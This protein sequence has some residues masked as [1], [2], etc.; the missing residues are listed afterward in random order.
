MLM[1]LANFATI[2]R[3][4]PKNLVILVINNRTYLT[5]DRGELESACAGR[6][7]L[8]G[9]ARAMGID[10]AVV[11][12]TPEQCERYIRQAM[13]EDGPWVVVANVDRTVVVD[14]QSEQEQPD[15]TELSIAFQHYLRDVRPAP[16]DQPGSGPIGSNLPAQ[17]EG[18][19]RAAARVIYDALKAAG[20]DFIAYLPDSV[21]YPVQELAEGDPA[22]PAICCTRED[23]GVAIAAGAAYGGRSPAIVMEGTGVGLAGQALAGLIVRR[24]PLLIVSSHPEALGIRAPHDNIACMVNE[25]ILRALHITSAVLTHLR[26]AGV[27]IGEAQ[28]AAQVL[29]GPVA[30]LVP[31]YVMNEAAG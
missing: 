10:G 29:K 16:R 25:P 31:P 8:A 11:A 4:L 26:D 1:G 14:A 6:A 3:Y 12:D 23:E 22:M 24:N 19:G 27:V 18:P 13:L 15:R 20:I 2:G 30:V 7:D 28:R 17:T 5:T 21:L 9:A